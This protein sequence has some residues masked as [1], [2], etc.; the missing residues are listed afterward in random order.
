MQND[1]V[2]KALSSIRQKLEG[3]NAAIA[4]LACLK[5]GVDGCS[6]TATCGEHRVDDDERLVLNAL[7][8]NVFR[9]YTYFCMLAVD[10]HA[11]GRNKAV[12][13]LVEHIQESL[14]E[15]QPGSQYGGNH[16]VFL[17]QG[18]V[19]G[20]QRRGDGLGLVLQGFR[21]LV[22]HD[23]ANALDVMTKQKAVLLVILV[24]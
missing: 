5:Q 22:S 6:Q 1:A 8:G 3:I 17:R 7:C 20:S 15:R 24:A 21:E 10:I 4:S 2:G 23:L 18:D 12:V 11:E 16:H 9:V 19:D 14:V 13:G